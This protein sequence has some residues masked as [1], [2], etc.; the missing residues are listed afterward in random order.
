MFSVQSL[1]CSYFISSIVC[2]VL[3]RLE[4]D[5]SGLTVS[6]GRG[7][8]ERRKLLK[9][10]DIFKGLS[11]EEIAD[12]DRLCEEREY[13]K[14]EIILSENS[15]GNEIFI[16]KKGKIRIDLAVKGRDDS[17]TVHRIAEGQTFGELALVDRGR[18]C[19]TACSEMDSTVLVIG[20]ERLQ[21]LFEQ[22]HRIGYVVMKNIAALL[23]V[24]LRK[25]NLQLIASILWE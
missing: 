6:I 8:M 9:K 11:D 19:A 12:I 18:R 24:R 4:T 20:R 25:T 13:R 17:A 3:T 1:S 15:L 22:N 16:L 10:V 14:N 5:K 21:E 23:A 7:I 2:F